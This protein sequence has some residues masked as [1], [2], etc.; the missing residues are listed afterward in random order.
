MLQ[1]VDDAGTNRAV[2]TNMA[3]NGDGMVSEFELS[4]GL[5]AFVT[6]DAPRERCKLSH[7]G[8]LCLVPVNAY[9]ELL[10][11]QFSLHTKQPKPPSGLPNGLPGSSAK[12]SPFVYHHP[13]LVV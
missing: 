13:N 2:V 10:S 7:L 12:I 8:Q 11:K 5:N 6:N 3:V 4:W 1:V 9:F